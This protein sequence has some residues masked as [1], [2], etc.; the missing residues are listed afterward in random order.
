MENVKEEDLDKVERNQAKEFYIDIPLK[1]DKL[2]LMFENR[3]ELSQWHDAIIQ[4]IN[5]D[6]YE[7][8]ELKENFLYESEDSGRS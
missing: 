3:E 7:D 6:A 4:A 1:K 2:C 5:M 8:N